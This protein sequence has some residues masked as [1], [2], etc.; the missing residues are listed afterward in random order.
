MLCMTKKNSNMRSKGKI[1]SPKNQTSSSV[2]GSVNRSLKTVMLAVCVIPLVCLLYFY[3]LGRN[4]YHDK[5]LSAVYGLVMGL[6]FLVALGV[7]AFLLYRYEAQKRTSKRAGVKFNST[8]LASWVLLI[9]LFFSYLSSAVYGPGF[10]NIVTLALAVM[11]APLALIVLPRTPKIGSLVFGV[12]AL[13]IMTLEVAMIAST[14]TM[15]DGVWTVGVPSW[16]GLAANVFAAT[17]LFTRSF[18]R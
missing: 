8:L 16:L 17:V 5:S 10:S 18:G 3:L 4:L 7:G 11:A 15:G 14:N 13:L 1:E 12:I 6:G 2:S 9:A